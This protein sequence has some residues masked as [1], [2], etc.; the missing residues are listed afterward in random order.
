M[1]HY[2]GGE[3]LLIPEGFYGKKGEFKK[4]RLYCKKCKKEIYY[5][6]FI[7][8]FRKIIKL[9]SLLINQLEELMEEDVRIYEKIDI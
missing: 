2:C 7:K 3:I 9:L 6:D 4:E 1:K 8:D 5:T